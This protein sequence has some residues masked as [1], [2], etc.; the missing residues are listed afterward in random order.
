MGG[1]GRGLAAFVDVVIRQTGG[2]DID[3]GAARASVPETR[4]AWLMTRPS[5]PP[6]LFIALSLWTGT[7]LSIDML[8]GASV[9]C[10]QLV[11][12]ASLLIAATALVLLFQG[13]ALPGCLALGF[14]LGCLA[15][16]V[17]AQALIVGQEALC[18]CT[19]PQMLE[20][21]ADSR[22]GSFGRLATAVTAEGCRVRVSLPDEARL[23]SG[24]A[25]EAS[26]WKAP[27]EKLARRYWR[28]GVVA[29]AKGRAAKE[30][31]ASPLEPVRAFRR[32]AVREVDACANRTIGDIE[33]REAGM[34]VCAIVMG[35]TDG[36]YDSALYQAVKVDGLAHLV[37]VSGAHLSIVAGA[38]AIAMR[39]LPFGRPASIA[40][41][42]I[43]IG[44]Y[45]VFTGAPRS[46][47]RAAVMTSLGLL[48]FVP[49]RRPYAVGSLSCCIAV[50]IAADP[51]NAF[52]TSLLLSAA[53]TLGIVLFL[54]F[55]SQ[56]LTVC[57]GL[58]AGAVRDSLALTLAAT[59]TTAPVCAA[60]F[61]QASAITPVAN[62][63]VAPAFP[64][65]CI[66]G[67][68]SVAAAVLLGSVG[69]ALMCALLVPASAVCLVLQVLALVPGAAFPVSLDLL[70]GTVL[71]FGLPVA[72]W[73]AWPY[74][75]WGFLRAAAV[76]LAIAVAFA[77]AVP[78]VRGDVI[79]MLD[80]GQGDAFLVQGG[81][82]A[83]L[84]D[85][86]TQ[87]TALLEGL[88]SCG[89]RR[90]DAVLIT[91]PDDDH[92]GSLRALKGIVG[93]GKVLVARDLLADSDEH[94]VRLR[95]QA[96]QVAGAD[97]L[98]GLSVGDSLALGGFRFD[99]IGPDAYAEGGGNAD[100]LVLS[101]AYDADADGRADATGI[102]CGDAESPQLARYAA[103]GR[104]SDVDILKVGHHGSRASVDGAVLSLMKPE[105]ALVSV[106][107][108][109]SYG[110]PAPQTIEALEAAGSAVFRT[111][112]HG[113]VSC[114]LRADGI[115]VVTQR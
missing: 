98:V 25:V 56:M 72:F 78:L 6:M 67:F 90:L 15:G 84:I 32:Q 106:G 65:I 36:L 75:G 74:P 88:A 39:R 20:L 13:A 41:Q 9:D 30:R 37:A 27:A 48:S 66:G 68:A 42:V 17:H 93:V 21:V 111:D 86:G 115:H 29:V 77:L 43:L 83:L 97:G 38:V 73:L 95:S 91:H 61:G 12:I 18:A 103:A 70:W 92:C 23:L 55:F 62:L 82:R 69:E 63:L 3:W 102:F 79:T 14:A 46:A 49:G 59:L 81:G 108:G 80:I 107:V 71:A 11:A 1:H 50:M 4:G 22:A 28:D 34:L 96:A 109:N 16:S 64:L 104:I 94:C 58:Q 51:A 10:C 53:A 26:G 24:D 57:F 105:I 113:A 7:A 76:V 52:S 40:L 85:T 8:F 5:L 33:L 44:C 45:L 2:R 100:S 110:H 101:M 114:Y 31:P 19:Q 47:V 87:D 35:Y 54:S 112:E 89:V 99:V 60:A